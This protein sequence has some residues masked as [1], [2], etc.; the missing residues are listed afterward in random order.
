MTTVEINLTQDRL[1]NNLLE[2]Q[3]QES[4]LN[5]F[6]FGIGIW[7]M[8]IC[9]IGTPMNA[10][11]FCLA[12]WM[13]R[14]GGA[15][16]GGKQ[17]W[18]VASMTAADF[19]FCSI[20]SPMFFALYSLERPFNE[21]S[22]SFFYLTT[23][24][25]IVASSLS[26]LLLNVDKFLAL[27]KPLHYPSLMTTRRVVGLL[28]AFWLLS[29]GWAAF[30]VFGPLLTSIS[31]C[32]FK[33]KPNYRIMYYAFAVVFFALPVCISV[34]IAIFV[35]IVA[36]RSRSSSLRVKA[37]A[38]RHLASRWLLEI[39]LAASKDLEKRQQQQER[40]KNVKAITF[41]FCTT[42][43]SAITLL[44]YRFAFIM[45]LLGYKSVLWPSIFLTMTTM[46]ALGK[47]I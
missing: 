4:L 13:S 20:H 18:F 26:L 19:L 3:R 5:N 43:W 30:L 8:V 23:H 15:A 42:L 45:T 47:T 12:I 37:G 29:I 46:N 11:V 35:T 33:F 40:R 28:V 2:L 24:I 41:V 21:Y 34:F 27:H 44:P 36:K 6:M 7:E 22:C 1:E 31:N 14:E 39:E 17:Q 38:G 25:S 32:G 16:T 9:A 10:L